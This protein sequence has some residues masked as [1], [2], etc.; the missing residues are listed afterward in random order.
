MRVLVMAK[1]NTTIILDF[2]GATFGGAGKGF[3]RL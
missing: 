2:N 1:T 3:V